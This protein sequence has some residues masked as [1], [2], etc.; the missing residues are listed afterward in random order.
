MGHTSIQSGKVRLESVSRHASIRLMAYSTDNNQLKAS[1]VSRAV[2]G[3]ITLTAIPN[4]ISK[5]RLRRSASKQQK[6][7][8]LIRECQPHD[9]RPLLS[10]GAETNQASVWQNMGRSEGSRGSRR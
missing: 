10:G 3:N 5:H 7:S 4:I 1:L 8:F 6:L 2:P 9:V